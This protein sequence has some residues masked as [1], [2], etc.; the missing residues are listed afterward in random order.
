MIDLY[1]IEQ[2]KR[3]MTRRARIAES[4]ARYYIR[5][6]SERRGWKL[7]HIA[8]GGDCLEEQE[9]TGAFP[10]IGL[11]Q[12]KPDFLFCLGGMPAVVIEAKNE[13]GKVSQALREATDYADDINSHGKYRVKIAVGA[14]GEEQHGFDVDVA[15]LRRNHWVPLTSKSYALTTIPSKREAELALEADDA[16]TTVTVPTSSEFID[17]A[18][19]LSSILRQAKVE[20]PLRP[21]VIGAIVLALYQGDVA[22]GDDALGSLNSL[23]NAAIEES[24]DLDKTKKNRLIDALRLTGNDYDRLSP[25]IGRIV[26]L[27]RRLNIRSVL[28][29]D[30]DFLGL[31]YEAFLR[32]GY[33]NNALGIVF[34]PRHITNFCA[35]LTSPTM[36]YR[37]MDVACGTGG[38]LVAAFDRMLASAHGPK[39]IAKVK[40]SLYGF[41]TNPTIWALATLN[42][43][44]RGD[45]KSHIENVSCFDG[46]SKSVTRQHFTR[47]FLNPPFSQEGEPERE[48]ID[49]SMDALEPGGILATVVKAGIFADDD[50]KEWRDRF[51]KNHSVEAVI[52]LPED[53]FYPTAAPTSILIATAHIPQKR[54]D[55]IMLGRV[56]NDGFE[57][58]KGKRVETVGSQLPEIVEALRCF[59]RKEEPAS[60]IVKVIEANA[61]LSGNEWSPQQYLDNL[62]SPEEAHEQHRRSVVMDLYK[63]TVTM[64]ELAAEAIEDFGATWD[65]LN[66]LP[67]GLTEPVE[68]FF[69]VMTGKSQGEKHY[70]TGAYPYI[71]S[72][73]ATNSI[74]RLIDSDSDEVFRDGGITVTAFGQAC[75]QPWAFTARGNGGSAVRVLI[76]KFAMSLNEMVWF[77]CQI[78]FQRWRFFYGRMA[79]KSRLERLLIA[80]PT[81]QIEDRGEG[82]RERLTHF[83][84]TLIALSGAI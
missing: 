47:T 6:I 20:A 62:I 80:S 50:N 58:L 81:K 16:T 84:E 13:A 35:D 46:A 72:G 83:H 12:D 25:M 76:P 70:T 64:P 42:M 39:A 34:T 53:L 18:V 28:Q 61:I 5:Q 68:F 33:D 29:T 17:A 7:N 24:V 1:R 60:R 43:F 69:E 79:I 4:R 63:A 30:T 9:I 15:Y 14:A 22:I 8:R 59:K 73:D 54:D 55:R 75:L 48:F 3:D 27:L 26:A 45:G 52:S 56:W 37:V 66:P 40:Q 74:I 77:A 44:F 10:D 11:G 71:S 31:F 49:V 19:E 41:D 65:S 32:Y 67:I 36:A 82:I 2:Y 78:N 21:K 23:A 51:T 38:F 57:K